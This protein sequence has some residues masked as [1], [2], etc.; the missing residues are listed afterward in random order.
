MLAVQT[1]MSSMREI[2]QAG[3]LSGAPRRHHTNRADR[4]SDRT[5]VTSAVAPPPRAEAAPHVNRRPRRAAR[6]G[7]IACAIG[8]V[9]PPPAQKNTRLKGR[10]RMVD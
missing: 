5:G 1:E 6:R 3:G 9:V 7:P 8:S 2:V 10:V 4:A